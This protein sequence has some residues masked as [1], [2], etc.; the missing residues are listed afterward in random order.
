VYSIYGRCNRGNRRTLSKSPLVFRS[1]ATIVIKPG[2]EALD[3]LL[4]EESYEEL[5]GFKGFNLG[6]HLGELEGIVTA[7]AAIAVG[8]G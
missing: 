6:K 5:R 8:S 4:S 2:V 7:D 1:I 3:M